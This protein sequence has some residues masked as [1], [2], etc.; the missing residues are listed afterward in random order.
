MNKLKKQ[1]QKLPKFKSEDAERDFWATHSITDFFD[2]KK[3]IVNPVFPNLK[4]SAKTI[5]LRIPASM[6]YRLKML[7]NEKDV[8]YQSYMKILLDKGIKEESKR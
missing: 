7:A 5:S 8:P 3:V 6:L 2:T 1:F 4:P